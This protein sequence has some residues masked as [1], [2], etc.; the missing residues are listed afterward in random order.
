M[1]VYDKFHLLRMLNECVD[2]VRR[3][4]RL[5][6]EGRQLLKHKRFLLLKGQ[7]R[8]NP[9]PQQTQK[10]L[11]DQ[12]QALQAAHLLKEQF[13]QMFFIAPDD[14]KAA[15]LFAACE[16]M[17]RGALDEHII[18]ER[19]LLSATQFDALTSP[20]AVM[21]LGRPAR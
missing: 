1:I 20:E 12:N 5:T 13:R 6:E 4:A 8:L 19:G 16:E 10:E 11:L 3:Q 17:M 15:A 9:D 18:V 2:D 14:A 21:R 7:E